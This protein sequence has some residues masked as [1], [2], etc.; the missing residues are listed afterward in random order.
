MSLFGAYSKYYDL[1]YRG[2]NYQAE[3]DYI[4]LIVKS[5]KPGA[6]KILDLGCGT[7]QHAD[8][9]AKKGYKVQGVDLSREMLQQTEKR[10][11]KENPCYMEGDIR[12]IRLGE[13]FDAVIALFHVISYQNTNEDILSSFKT[14][15]E[16]LRIGGIFIFDCWYGPAVLTECPEKRIKKFEDNKMEVI[17]IAEPIMHLNENIVDVNYQIIVKD[18]VTGSIEELFETHKMRYLF[19]PEVEMMMQLAGF[20]ITG[21]YKYLSYAMPDQHSWHVVFFSKKQ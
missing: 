10:G 8:L 3:V 16:H 1:L 15:Y 9:L 18:K 4:D 12:T 17:R 6:K 13:S 2:K 21:F 7:G 20:K 14:A 11:N 19:R 5:E